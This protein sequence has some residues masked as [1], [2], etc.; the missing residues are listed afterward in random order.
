MNRHPY[1]GLRATRPASTNPPCPE[2]SGIIVG[3]GTA[4]TETDNGPV[5]STAATLLLD[6]GSHIEP[7]LWSLRVDAAEAAAHI[8]RMTRGLPSVGASPI[9][10]TLLPPNDE[11]MGL[12]LNLADRLAEHVGKAI[13]ILQIQNFQALCMAAGSFEMFSCSVE[14]IKMDVGTKA[15]EVAALVAEDISS[16]R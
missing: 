11:S 10:G 8:A 9:R 4:T 6:D 2:I 5:H 16:R 14:R 15:Q 12:S 1:I 3:I 13:Y 7:W